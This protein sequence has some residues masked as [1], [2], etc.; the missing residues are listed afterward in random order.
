MEEA[1][2]EDMGEYVRKMQNT[3]AQYISTWPILDLYEERVRIS[4]S[5]VAK[6]W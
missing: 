3:V 4:G 6:M 2:F 5:W 1:G